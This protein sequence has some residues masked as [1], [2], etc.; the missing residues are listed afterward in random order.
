MAKMKSNFRGY[1]TLAV[2]IA[3]AG[4]AA[5]HAAA[6]AKWVATWATAPE[7]IVSSQ[8]QFLP[9]SIGLANNSLRQVLRVSIGG[10]TLRMRFTN[11]YTPS[12]VTINAA[13][14]AISAGSGVIDT[15]TTRFFKFGGNDGITM[16]ANS[17][18]WSDP[19]P[20]SLPPGAQVQVT[21]H[22][23]TTPAYNA[24]PNV[25][26]HRGSRTAPLILAGNR[27]ADRTFA[28]ATTLANNGQGS[29]V[30]SS[31]EV[32]APQE[33]GAVA[34]LGNSITDGFGVANNA[35]TRWTDVF[36][37]RLL[38]HARTSKVGVLNGGIGAGNMVSGGVSTPG[39]QRYKRDLFDHSGVKWII[40]YLGVNDIG[41]ANA[42]LPTVAQNLINAYSQIAD[43]AR[44]RGIKAYGGTITPFNGNNYHNANREAARQTLNAWIRSTDK[45]DGVVDFDKIIRN[46][47]DT[48]RILAAYNNDWLH[49]SIAGYA[50]MG[51][52]IDTNLF[53]D[54]GTPVRAGAGPSAGHEL[55]GVRFA[56][57]AASRAS[58]RF[59]LAHEARVS[60]AVRSLDGR[61]VASVAP[62]AHGAGAH[63]AAF[64]AS[65]LS[66]GMYLVTMRADGFAAS[67]KVLVPGR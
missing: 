46:P 43:S 23:G 7:P 39:L 31:M 38:A 42:N 66:G 64:D 14:I 60:F 28:G 8:S 35:F 41:T 52:S 44:A 22:F 6:Q 36:T 17:F 59:V 27:V 30:I 53:I 47:S 26:G 57:A 9:P 15:N 13:T 1:Y 48:T 40:I 3:V 11:E 63:E 45:L 67:R 54:E 25:T 65:K 4:L 10:D 16:P 2:A 50:H 51:N 20:F 18:A 5:S 24:S 49:P 62:R 61:E 56:G 55:S 19:L 34:I 58:I 33:A 37:T 21:I 12:A 32:R 29:W